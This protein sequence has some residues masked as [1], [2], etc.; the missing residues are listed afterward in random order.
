MI[1]GDRKEVLAGDPGVQLR[2]VD[3]IVPVSATAIDHLPVDT[4]VADEV[5]A[6]SSGVG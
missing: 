5:H 3:D 4:L 1:V 2:Q 6:A